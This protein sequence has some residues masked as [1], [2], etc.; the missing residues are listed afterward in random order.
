MH[1]NVAKYICPECRNRILSDVFLIIDIQKR[2][3]RLWCPFCKVWWCIKIARKD[4]AGEGHL[5]QNRFSFTS[6]NRGNT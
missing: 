6:V 5:L 4:I 1:A 2:I 3:V